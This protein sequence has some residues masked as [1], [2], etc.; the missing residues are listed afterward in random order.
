MHEEK[1]QKGIF[2]PIE[3]SISIEEQ[4]K[5]QI[6]E[7]EKN[8]IARSIVKE[9]KRHLGSQ[10]RKSE[11]AYAYYKRQKKLEQRA[12]RMWKIQLKRIEAKK[13]AKKNN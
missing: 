1:Y 3:E 5:S 9:L 11:D 7:I 12:V 13:K 10:W 2:K 4:L 8:S 6:H